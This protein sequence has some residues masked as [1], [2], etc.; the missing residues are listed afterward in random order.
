M[1]TGF[2]IIKKGVTAYVVYFLQ[3]RVKVELKFVS[4]LISL[5][6]KTVG[7]TP[8]RVQDEKPSSQ[9]P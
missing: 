3:P 1:F 5:S 6:A 8:Y 4:D 9:T 7:G 2:G